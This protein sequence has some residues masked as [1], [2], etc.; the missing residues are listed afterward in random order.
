MS[1]LAMVLTDFGSG[2]VERM[3]IN[4]ARGLA[5]EGVAV[6]LLVDD[7]DHPQLDP[8]PAG[9][10][11]IAL[12]ARG[13][14]AEPALRRYLAS[15]PRWL[16]SAKIDDDRLVLAAR[17][18]A[19]ADASVLFRVG[20]PLAHRV[21]Q[22]RIGSVR[23]WWALRGL[24]ALYRRADGYVAVSRGIADD[25][26]DGLGVAR[27]RVHVLPNPTVTPELASAATRSSGHPWL[28][29][30]GDPVILAAGGLRQQK[31]FQTLLRAFAQVRERQRARLVILGEGRQRG[32]LEALS[33]RL[34]VGADVDLPGWTANP[35]AYMARA[36]L[37]V[38]SSR[39][40][41]SPNVLV[42]ALSLGVPVVATDCVSGPREILG[43]DGPG[44]LVPVADPQAL[45]RAMRL[46]LAQPPVAAALRRLAEPYTLARSARAY[47]E[48]LGLV[49]A[50]R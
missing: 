13:D 44:V 39:W 22:R 5:A 23:R 18:A 1:D 10:S 25:L 16:L 38:L 6:D 47:I 30:P 45:A 7:A 37:F 46:V 15:P 33:R 14:G 43:E 11:L 12:G 26:V 8:P 19:G 41:G 27:E 17:E 35:H 36:S 20:N 9:V 2:G 21:R 40:E 3:V 28:D 34:G 42:E 24:R 48:A 31:D 4:T 50:R 32:R 49:V 29:Q